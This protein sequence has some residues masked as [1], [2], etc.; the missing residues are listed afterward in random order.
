MDAQGRPFLW[1]PGHKEDFDLFKFFLTD[2]M[3]P[4]TNRDAAVFFY[5]KDWRSEHGKI[6][7]NMVRQARFQW[8]LRQLG[9]DNI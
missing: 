8:D 6:V 5:H 7:Q 9:V 4:P 3:E 2:R 1:E